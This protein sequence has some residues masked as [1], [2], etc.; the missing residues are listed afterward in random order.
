MNLIPLPYRILAGIVLLLAFGA[1]CMN[2][3]I[4][5]E[6]ADWLEKE[7]A[8]Q[9]NEK[10]AILDRVAENERIQRENDAKNRAISADYENRLAVLRKAS[11]ADRAAVNAAGGLRV[12]RSICDSPAAG[13]E[14]AGDRG[15]DETL[16]G[17]IR[18]PEQV[19]G[20]LW[21]F[22]DD[23]DEIVEQARACQQWILKH[24]FYGE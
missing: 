3:G 24:G 15:R 14:T 17:T 20:D 16:T 19:E 8:R 23:A 5:W 9:Q 18:L 12:P 7:A 11:A 21:A 6:R 10:D 13:T 22:A 1:G 2:V 4:K